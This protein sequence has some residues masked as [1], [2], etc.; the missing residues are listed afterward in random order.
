MRG[1]D[2]HVVLRDL[3]PGQ[4]MVHASDFMVTLYC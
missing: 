4:G 1:L 2:Q 3:V